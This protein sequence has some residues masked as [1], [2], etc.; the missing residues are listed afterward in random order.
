M[1]IL[2]GFDAQQVEPARPFDPIPTG[3]YLAE[4]D[5]SEM[6]SNKTGTGHFLELTFRIVNG[7]FTDRLLLARL[8][9]DNPNETAVRIARAELSAICRAVGVLAPKDSAE[10]H[11]L[12]LVI[13]VTVKKREDNGE[14]ANEINGYSRNH[15]SG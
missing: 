11:N 14:L 5:A 13:H 1:A 3:R 6:K 4:I 12:P 2:H 9:M 7:E 10:L 8:N 15:A